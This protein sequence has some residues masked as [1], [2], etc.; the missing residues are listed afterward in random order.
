MPPIYYPLHH[1][2]STSNSSPCGPTWIALGKNHLLTAGSRLGHSF[3]DN[4]KLR[5]YL[6][7][8]SGDAPAACL[9]SKRFT[10]ETQACGPASPGG[11]GGLEGGDQMGCPE[12]RT[13]VE[14]AAISVSSY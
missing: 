8:A 9:S 11:P 14:D 3:R 10:L 5:D 1:G 7:M 6:G 13:F 12:M 2:R 4:N